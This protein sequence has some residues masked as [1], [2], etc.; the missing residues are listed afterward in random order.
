MI[1]INNNNNKYII[2]IS[3]FNEYI[4]LELLLILGLYIDNNIDFGGSIP[5]MYNIIY[6]YI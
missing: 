2:L 6:Y 3:C 5:L 4:Q 1:T